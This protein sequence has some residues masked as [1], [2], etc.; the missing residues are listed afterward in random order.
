MNIYQELR[1]QWRS[2]TSTILF[3]AVIVT[4]CTSATI[5]TSVDFSGEWKLN[6]Q[7]SE[8]GQFGGRGAAK[9][10][11]VTSSDAKGIAIERTSTNQNG[12]AVVRKETLT[13]DGK[14]SESTGGFGNSTRKA[15]A[16]WS[17]DGN[18]L[19]VNYILNL[20]FNGQAF[21]VKG[22]ETWTLSSDGKTLTVQTN[23]ASPQG[24]LASKA[25]Y[26]KQ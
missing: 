9:A 6:E 23:A 18:A 22:T 3:A 15:T 24:D 8:L 21:E 19:T 11:K 25:V 26:D 1:R 17:D 20:D 4:L 2:R 7:K 5:V 16:K 13:F 12:E 14:E 10:I